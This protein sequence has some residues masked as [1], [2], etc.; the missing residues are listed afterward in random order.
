[1][2]TGYFNFSNEQEEYNLS[3]LLKNISLMSISEKVKSI[4]DYITGRI[5]GLAWFSATNNLKQSLHG[6]FKFW[7]V[8]SKSE[9]R[10]IGRTLLSELGAKERFFLKKSRTYDRAEISGYIKDGVL[11]FNE[12]EITNDIL[13]YRNLDIKVDKQKNSITVDHLLSVIDEIGKR[14]DEIKIEAN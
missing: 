11:T 12:F 13:G 6:P 7:S 10:K 9:S 3:L 8:K 5:N 14:A 4:E 1:M 2:G